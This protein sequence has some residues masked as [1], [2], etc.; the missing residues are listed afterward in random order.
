MCAL[1]FPITWIKN[2]HAHVHTE[3]EKEKEISEQK[4]ENPSDFFKV[5]A[6]E[7]VR[8]KKTLEFQLRLSKLAILSPSE[9]L[10]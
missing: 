4:K 7:Y 10:H 3:R 1:V 2:Q 6:K 9:S 8:L 5:T